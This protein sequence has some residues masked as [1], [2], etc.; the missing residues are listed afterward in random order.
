VKRNQT[1]LL[2][3]IARGK[4]LSEIGSCPRYLMALR[5]C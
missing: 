2:I 5:E 3:L 4:T 1:R